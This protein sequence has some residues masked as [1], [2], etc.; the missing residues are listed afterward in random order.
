MA[1]VVVTG[2]SG[3]LGSHVRSALAG[4]GHDVVAVGRHASRA[5]GWVQADV[6]TGA[7]MDV[8]LRGAEAVVH[9][10][11][12]PRPDVL[13]VAAIQWIRRAAPDARI[14]YPSIVGADAIAFPYYT[15]KVQ[16]EEVLAGGPHALLRLT[17]FHEFPHQVA[18]W[19]SPTIPR[20]FRT[21]P[22]A[23][24]EAAALL[25]ACVEG[26]GG[27]RPDAGGPEVQDLAALVRRVLAAQGRPTQVVEADG[28]A[29]AGFR[30]GANLCPEN[31]VGRQTWEEHF[32]DWLASG[33]PALR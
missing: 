8:A 23:A 25:A 5:A 6:E 20:G 17:Q 33:K 15:A 10:A 27:R 13:D 11:A 19:P 24:R 29:T 21:Q 14:V 18:A 30:R 26:P 12:G 2:A 9:C 4:L 31:R 1:R 3:V 28:P 32:H 7:G 16:A 22:I